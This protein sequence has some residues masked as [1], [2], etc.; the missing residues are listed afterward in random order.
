MAQARGP[1]RQQMLHYAYRA[2][3][4]GVGATCVNTAS[5]STGDDEL[6]AMSSDSDIKNYPFVCG[7]YLIICSV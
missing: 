4:S 5:Q 2:T 7:M 3:P 1:Y 6:M